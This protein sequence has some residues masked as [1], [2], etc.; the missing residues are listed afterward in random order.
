MLDAV[1]EVEELKMKFP[2]TLEEMVKTSEEFRSKSS[3]NAISGCVGAVD[4]W[5]CLIQCPGKKEVSNPNSYF[6]GHYKCHGAN[7]QACCDVF[8]R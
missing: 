3:F 4:G 7:V 6:S 2:T 8:S 1:G 5:L